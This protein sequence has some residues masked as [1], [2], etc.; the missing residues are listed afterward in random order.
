[1]QLWKVNS[2]GGYLSNPK[3]SRTIRHAAQPMMKFRQFVR[4][5][6]GYGKNKGETITFNRISNVQNPGGKLKETSKMPETN[7]LITQGELVVNEYGNSIPYTGKLEDLAE[8]SVNNIFTVALRDDMAKTIDK[9][10]AETF[11]KGKVIYTATG[12]DAN[13]TFSISTNGTPAATAT[14]NNT[15]FDVKNIVDYMKSTLLVPKYD[16]VDYICV[17]S[18]AFLRKIKDDPSYERSAQYAQPEQLFRGEVGRY[19]ET[20]FIEETNS[21]SQVVGSTSF[22]GEAIFFGADPVIE[23]IAL[24]EEIRSKIPEDYGR[25]KGIAWYFLGG[26]APTF[27][28]GKPGEAKIVVYSSL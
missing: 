7:V 3:L 24:P 8:F 6:P 18:T 23:G 25:S 10:V 14:R 26:W 12:T 17:A 2:L 20:R 19:Y 16:G 15:T 9:E 21:L 4:P 22:A 13:P 28:T 11:K 27:D 5:E 1:M